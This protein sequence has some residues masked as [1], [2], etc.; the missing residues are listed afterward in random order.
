MLNQL[1]FSSVLTKITALIILSSTLSACGGG[2]STKSANHPPPSARFSHIK[3]HYDLLKQQ[4]FVWD[5]AQDTRNIDVSS[6]SAKGATILNVAD[7]TSLVVDQL[8]VYRS[9]NHYYIGQIQS[10]PNAQQIVLSSPLEG[11]VN[12]GNN[13]WDFYLNS[14]HPNKYGYRAIAD[15]A[16]KSLGFSSQTG[17][18]HVLLGDSWFD[19]SNG[20]TESIFTRLNKKLTGAT[21]I[22][23]GTGGN[24]AQDLLNRFDTDVTPKN[25]EYIWILTGTND[26]WQGVTTAQYKTNL[27]KLINKSKAIGAKVIIFDSSVGIGTGDKN[28]PNQQRSKEYADAVLELY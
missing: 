27:N 9:S 8:I 19:D 10:L 1:T 3:M 26:Y 12:S 28:T 14:A 13:V 15:F 24:T 23:E 20:T 16:I 4:P 21:L 5:E 7:S 18:K 11:A 25:P 6:Y 2:G 22:N 17:G